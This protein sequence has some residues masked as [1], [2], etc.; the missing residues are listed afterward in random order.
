[1][2]CLAVKL[3]AA[4]TSFT[5]ICLAT[6]TDDTVL[7]TE[8]SIGGYNLYCHCSSQPPCHGCGPSPSRPPSPA[9]VNCGA[10]A[11]ASGWVRA[12][13]I[14]MTDTTRNCPNGLKF[15]T[16]SSKR[17]CA[18]TKGGCTSVFFPI[19]VS[20]SKVCG[21]VKGY[22][23]GWMEAFRGQSLTVDGQYVHGLS[24]THG[25]KPRNH[26]WTFAVGTSKDYYTNSWNC[27]CAVSPGSDPQSFVRENYFCESGDTGTYKYGVWYMNDPLFDSKGCLPGSSCCKR[28]GP[29]FTTTL[30]QA[31]SNDLE[32]RWCT[33]SSATYGTIGVEQLEIYVS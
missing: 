11:S 7:V 33:Y 13:F 1:M 25:S 30:N 21:R 14:N 15:E 4:L 32:V 20:Y 29:W 16:A 19:S 17:M 22:Q 24:V 18:T 10:A 12:A 3:L 2:F 27:P 31:T 9:T 28:G 8:S 26:I 6:G 5:V 23:T